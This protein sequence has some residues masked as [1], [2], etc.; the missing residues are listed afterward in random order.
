MHN[1][2]F[3]NSSIYSCRVHHISCKKSR[4]KSG[5]RLWQKSQLPRYVEKIEKKILILI[6]IAGLWLFVASAFA[7]LYLLEL[8][9]LARFNSFFGFEYR[10]LIHFFKF[11]FCFL[12]DF[13]F[14]LKLGPMGP[15][16]GV[17]TQGRG[18]NENRKTI[19]F[20]IQYTVY[21]TVQSI[22]H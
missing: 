7:K 10:F 17:G 8:K 19:L 20:E 12:F 11:I 9:L 3:S 18:G 15:R 6:W 4:L 22:F 2:F 1:S 16:G 13:R 5:D 14:S 21:L